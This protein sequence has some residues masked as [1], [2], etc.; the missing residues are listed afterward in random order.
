MLSHFHILRYYRGLADSD[1]INQMASREAT[2]RRIVV[3]RLDRMSDPSVDSGKR[4]SWNKQMK[5]L[6]WLL[7]HFRI[8]EDDLVTTL[9]VMGGGRGSLWTPGHAL[10]K[11]FSREEGMS[12][13]EEDKVEMVSMEV[14]VQTLC[15]RLESERL[16]SEDENPTRS[17]PFHLL[18]LTELPNPWENRGALM[19]K[20][21]TQLK[22]ISACTKSH[23]ISLATTIST[24]TAQS[25]PPNHSFSLPLTQA[26]IQACRTSLSF[27]QNLWSRI[28]GVS[29]SLVLP[30]PDLHSVSSSTPPPPLYGFTT[31][32]DQHGKQ[33]THLLLQNT[34]S[35]DKFASE[36]FNRPLC[37]TLL[38][39]LPPNTLPSYV[40][41]AV[42]YYV[43]TFP[44]Q[45]YSKPLVS[46]L[47]TASLLLTTHHSNEVP[48]K[49]FV[50][51]FDAITDGIILRSLHNP[52]DP[53]YMRICQVLHATQE[54]AVGVGVKAGG[55]VLEEARRL[56]GKVYVP[57][58][59][60][61]KACWA[62]VC[63]GRGPPIHSQTLPLD[64]AKTWQPNSLRRLE[65][66]WL[67]TRLD[68]LTRADEACPAISS[69]WDEK[70]C[71]LEVAT[72]SEILRKFALRSHLDEV[73]LQKGRIASSRD[74]ATSSD[75]CDW[76]IPLEVWEDPYDRSKDISR[77]GKASNTRGKE[78]GS[79][80]GF[81]LF[82]WHGESHGSK[83]THKREREVSISLRASKRPLYESSQ[84]KRR[85]LLRSFIPNNPNQPGT[86][87][88]S[89]PR[90]KKTIP[91]A[92]QPLRERNRNTEKKKANLNAE[93]A[94]KT[95]SK[96]VLRGREKEDNSLSVQERNLT[97]LKSCVN[98]VL[99]DH[100]PRGNGEY[101]RIF[102]KAKTI[103]RVLMGARLR[104]GRLTK[105]ELTRFVR[106]RIEGILR[107]IRDE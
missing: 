95:Q 96:R 94:A 38:A 28:L 83:H 60:D 13:E 44:G 86:A 35:E 105:G 39:S 12:G 72:P 53:I 32:S 49:L 79:V 6:R 50:L 26:Q 36:W 102:R 99:R 2:A 23:L 43:H 8:G 57:V 34:K 90:L 76:K 52:E 73:Q 41:S 101:G 21:V 56:E 1:G 98:A 71:P 87:N 89:T 62:S 74:P 37:L 77:R 9:P 85:K 75:A 100:V 40:Y 19:S 91:T 84:R 70:R 54:A 3:A 81:R 92:P 65:E 7:G 22:A 59:D 97:K 30:L 31:L 61:L 67:T 51:S 11:L 82:R 80:V 104:K 58:I 15:S 24:D 47:Q 10:D 66:L 27:R 63:E 25:H 93:H 18:V 64:R 69:S 103:F 46:T 29:S 14:Q 78:F 107:D 16:N 68:N 88:K 42:E 48:E 5:V 4:W 106:E 45:S 17:A 33:I 20:L 55:L